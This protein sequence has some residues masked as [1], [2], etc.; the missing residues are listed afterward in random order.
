MIDDRSTR[1]KK[2]V[3]YAN[4]ILRNAVRA[5]GIDEA[6][7]VRTDLSSILK[8]AI[9]NAETADMLSKEVGDLYPETSKHIDRHA[10]VERVFKGVNEILLNTL[11]VMADYGDLSLCLGMYETYNKL[12]EEKYDVAVVDVTTVVDLDDNLRNLIIKKAQNELDSNVILHEHINKNILGGIIIEARNRIIDCSL[13]TILEKTKS[14]L[15][16]I[17]H[18]G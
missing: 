10:F 9:D 12:L 16:S 3:A 2:E 8:A 5:G 7:R 6:I 15:T 4:S 13:L 18:Y 17:H 11:I 14:E 1:K